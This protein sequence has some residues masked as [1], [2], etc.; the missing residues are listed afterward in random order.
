MIP[1]FRNQKIVFTLLLT[2][3]FSVD[4][5]A[6]ARN[7]P[8]IAVYVTGSDIGSEVNTALATRLLEAFVNSK[9][10][11]AV[12]RSEMFMAEVEKEHIKQRSGAVDDEQIRRL[13]K[14]AGVQFVC[15]A[16]ITRAFETYQ[17]SARI[18]DIET[19]EVSV[20][21]VV[22]SPLRTMNDLT[23][24]AR[25]IVA[26]I[27]GTSQQTVSGQSE[28]RQTEHA[29]TIPAHPVPVSVVPRPTPS[30]V[31]HTT[32]EKHGGTSIG[33]RFAL[34][35]LNMPVVMS[36]DIVYHHPIL[37]AINVGYLYW[38]FGLE[39]GLA[40]TTSISH[41][42]AINSGVNLT[43]RQSHRL[44]GIYESVGT[45]PNMELIDI[46]SVAWKEVAL[47]IPALLQ[48][49]YWPPNAY[50]QGGLR[51]DIVL[52]TTYNVPN[53]K[54]PEST[55]AIGG[56]LGVGSRIHPNFAIGCNFY[57]GIGKNGIFTEANLDLTYF[58]M[59]VRR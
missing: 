52:S 31:L 23:M 7:L 14:Q 10:Y 35:A 41:D 15:V 13:G 12:E 50:L 19:A 16:N 6:R 5:F 34:F 46:P 33:T 39:M 54:I 3:L 43:L 11:V 1:T 49:V 29:R 42:I 2:L 45:S 38:G 47:T 25:L 18:I 53:I 22:D 56:I 28:P 48:L 57:L 40:I 59:R 17:V 9:Q 21:G 27:L 37:G 24:A 4:V 51:L 58:F 44:V 30:P 55:T 26:K 8:K 32:P 20:I 36:G